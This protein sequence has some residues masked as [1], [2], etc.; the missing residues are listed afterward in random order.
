MN[1]GNFIKTKI[2]CTARETINKTKRKPSEWEKI[3]ANDISDKELVSKS[4][5]GLIELNTQKTNNPVKKW[6]E[7]MNRHFSREDLQITNRRMKK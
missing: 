2:F 4:Y 3:F 7:D 5:K 6:A 1:Y